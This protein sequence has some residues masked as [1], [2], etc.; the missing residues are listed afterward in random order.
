L[1]YQKVQWGEEDSNLRSHKTTDLQSAPVGRFGISPIIKELKSLLTDS[2]RR[3][4]D[5]KS[6]AL[7]AELRRPDPFFKG[8]AKLIEKTF[9]TKIFYEEV[10]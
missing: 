4:T 6:V 1:V 5:Y 9:S 2:N 7:P 8:I 10:S 3:P